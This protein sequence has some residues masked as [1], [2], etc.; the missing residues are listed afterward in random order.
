MTAQMG[1][2]PIIFGFWLLGYALG[3]VAYIVRVPFLVGIVA[4]FGA[5][6]AE[7]VGAMI[8]GLAGSLVMLVFLLVWSH[9]GSS[10]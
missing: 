3:F 7:V 1:R 10:N 9:M 5:A 4:I 6:N 2:G 8:S